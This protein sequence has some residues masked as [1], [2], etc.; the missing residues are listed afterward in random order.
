MTSCLA[1]ALPGDAILLI[2]HGVYCTTV[3]AAEDV[4]VYALD[5]DVR[6]RGLA[7]KIAAHVQLIDDAGFVELACNHNPIVTWS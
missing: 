2:E 3:A 5:V 6:A 1:A 4:T 7:D